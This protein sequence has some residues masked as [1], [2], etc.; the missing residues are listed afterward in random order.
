MVLVDA[1]PLVALVDAQDQYH[2]KCV[3]AL[4]NLREP[5]ATLWPNVTEAM[6]HVLGIL[7][8]QDALIELLQ[9]G[10]L[11][12]LPLGSADL[13]RIRELMRQYCDL[14]MDFADAALIRVAERDGIKAFFTLDRRDFSVYRLNGRTRPELIP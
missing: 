5:V 9:T 4:G 14:P 13:P 10:A 12:L 11:K 2:E 7:P 1:G 3:R 6:Y 8:A